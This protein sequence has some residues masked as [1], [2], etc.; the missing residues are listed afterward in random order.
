MCE[1]Q[2]NKSHIITCYPPKNDNVTGKIPMLQLLLR[3]KSFIVTGSTGFTATLVWN[4]MILC[5]VTA[6]LTGSTAYASLCACFCT[7]ISSNVTVNPSRSAMLQVLV[8]CY[9]D[10]RPNSLLFQDEN[11][12]CYGCVSAQNTVTA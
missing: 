9:S 10:N 1:M 5:Y 2:R 4:E 6:Y 3:M 11:E 7:N 12:C 8:R